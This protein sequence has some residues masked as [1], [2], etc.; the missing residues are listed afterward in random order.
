MSQFKFSFQRVLDIKENEKELAEIQM[1]EAIK[2]QAEAYKKNENIHDKLNATHD[3][4]HQ[5]QKEGIHVFELRMLGQY[6]DQL[7]QELITSSREVRQVDGNVQRTQNHLRT[8]MKETKIWLNLKDKKQQ[9]HHQQN[10]QIEQSFLDEMATI[11]FSRLTTE[12]G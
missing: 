2:K 4:I 9:E 1:A 3:I 7:K 5:K 12:R 11:R 8:K 10:K 6:A